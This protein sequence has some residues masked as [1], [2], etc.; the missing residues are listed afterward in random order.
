MKDDKMKLENLV[1]VHLL[2]ENILTPFLLNLL[3]NFVRR[4][5]SELQGSLAGQHCA[6]RGCYNQIFSSPRYSTCLP[7]Y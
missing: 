5:E 4:T 6:Q 1:T 2:S 7:S 3:Y